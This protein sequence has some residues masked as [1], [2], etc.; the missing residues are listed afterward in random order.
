VTTFNSYKAVDHP[1]KMC[2]R[3]WSGYTKYIRQQCKKDKHVDSLFFGTYVKKESEAKDPE[4]NVQ[5]KLL[6]DT[7]NHFPSLKSTSKLDD[8][9]AE[10]E[11]SCVNL[12]SIAQVC[13]CTHDQ[14]I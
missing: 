3:I 12:N 9:Y 5:Y 2:Q 13:G 11:A 6:A 14:L 4:D 7:N 10:Q 1:F 8:S